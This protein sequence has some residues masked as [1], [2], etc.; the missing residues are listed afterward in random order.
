[1]KSNL[2][3]HKPVFSN[4]FFFQQSVYLTIASY[5]ISLVLADRRKPFS[6]REITKEVII[7]DAES[8]FDGL[9]DKSEIMSSMRDIQLS[10]QAVA[11]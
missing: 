4:S 3:L 2:A 8:I 10:H 9:R 11:K 7:D 5:K 6:N 1:M